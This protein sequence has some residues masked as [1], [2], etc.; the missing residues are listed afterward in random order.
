M[1][2]DVQRNV[3]E[4]VTLQPIAAAAF[5]VWQAVLNPVLRGMEHALQRPACKPA[6]TSNIKI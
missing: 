5:Q 6:L 4:M 1:T 2:H 3:P